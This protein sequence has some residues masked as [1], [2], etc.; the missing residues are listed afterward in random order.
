MLQKGTIF[1]DNY[2]MDKKLLV[3]FRKF[4][5]DSFTSGLGNFSDR[6]SNINTIIIRNCRFDDA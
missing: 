1:M 4:V 6:S 2:R 5:I 3:A